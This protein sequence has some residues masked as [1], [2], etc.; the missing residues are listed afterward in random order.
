LKQN[1][2]QS[3][4]TAR[5]LGQLPK[6]RKGNLVRL[7]IQVLFFLIIASIAF[8]QWLEGMRMTIPWLSTACL[9][10]I[11]P[12]GG[13][14]SIYQLAT[15]GSFVQ[16]IDQSAMVL[17]YIV[18]ALTLVAGPLFCGWVCP[19]GSFQEWLAG[20]G[21]KLF[22]KRFN[23]FISPQIDRYL[24]F[25]RYVV[26]A[27]VLYATAVSARLVF[28]DYD[29]Y[30]ALFKFWSGEVAI[31]S[32]IMLGLVIIAS[33]FIERPFC[34]YAC[35]YG[36]LLGLFNFFSLFPLRRSKARCI[37]CKLCD[38]SCPMNQQCISCLKCTSEFSCPVAN[39]VAL[40]M[41]KL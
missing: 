30:H 14:V 4:A 8:N 13:V 18:F 15:T 11:C 22:R 26:L 37:N 32:L 19:F 3:N 12:F 25:L 6:N 9:H 7:A 41:T 38:R 40:S 28:A 24:R 21:K 16:K 35:P 34:K 33:L 5:E 2:T 29:P 39:T 36:A 27:L 20:V 17:M 10:A 23:E 31:S 1:A